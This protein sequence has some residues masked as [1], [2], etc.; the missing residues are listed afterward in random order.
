MNNRCNCLFCEII[1]RKTNILYDHILYETENFCVITGLGAFIEGYLL[2]LTKE[3]VL[4]IAELDS[5]K[6]KELE[7]LKSLIKEAFRKIYNK[8]LIVFENGCSGTIGGRFKNSIGHAHIHLMPININEEIIHKIF[9]NIKYKT[10]QKIEDIL[11]FKK[12]PYIYFE[13]NDGSCYLSTDL[14][15]I[16]RQ[17]IRRII[18]ASIKIDKYNWREYKYFDNCHKTIEKLTDFFLTINL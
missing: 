10:L 15:D 8:Q 13:T 2:I 9:K 3:H 7:S 12:E 4:S 11:F 18:A 6:I 14:N 5:D 17:H 1:K 16:E